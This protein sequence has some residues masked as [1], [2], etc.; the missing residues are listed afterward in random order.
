MKKT[1]F[2]FNSPVLKDWLFYLFLLILIGNLSNSISR[3]ND[4]GGINTSIFSVF[5][6]LL[7]FSFQIFASWF[8]VVPIVF[9]IRKWLSKRKNQS[10]TNKFSDS[11]QV[12]NVEQKPKKWIERVRDASQE[13][14][15]KKLQAMA[16]IICPFCN[17]RGT[18]T[19]KEKVDTSGL[20]VTGAV[21]TF[22]LSQFITGGLKKHRTTIQASCSKCK[23]T[24]DMAT[25]KW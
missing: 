16:S 15:D 4:S 11:R 25:R 5:S 10:K 21:L 9:F 24:W 20:K 23:Q 12:K 2:L 3:V 8:P 19:T 17:Y 22:G 7:D 13:V 18:V 1:K 14:N 6:G